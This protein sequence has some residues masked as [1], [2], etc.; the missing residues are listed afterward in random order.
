MG[1]LGYIF[2][3]ALLFV[4]IVGCGTGYIAKV[5]LSLMEKTKKKGK[6]KDEKH[7]VSSGQPEMEKTDEQG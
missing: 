1:N 7:Q 6:E 3:Y 4:F 5:V 2:G